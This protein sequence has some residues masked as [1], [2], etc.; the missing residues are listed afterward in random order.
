MSKHSFTTCFIYTIIHVKARFYDPHFYV[1]IRHRVDT[2]LTPL[3]WFIWCWEIKIREAFTLYGICL[4]CRRPGFDPWAG[5]I[6]WRR[7]WLPIPVFWPGE[8]HGLQSMGLQRVGHDWATF[9]LHYM[10]VVQAVSSV[11]LYSLKTF[12]KSDLKHDKKR[13]SIWELSFQSLIFFPGHIFVLFPSNR[14]GFWDS[15]VSLVLI[16]IFF[17]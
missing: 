5:K 6:P 17:V 7:D 2:L 14:F 3:M 1:Q 4:Q 15:L 10:E 9:T 11:T 12:E 8:F 13:K 16:F